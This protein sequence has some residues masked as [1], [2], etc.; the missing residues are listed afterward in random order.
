MVEVGVFRITKTH[1][2]CDASFLQLKHIIFRFGIGAAVD[3]SLAESIDE[4]GS[5]KLAI[6]FNGLTVH[7]EETVIS[8]LISPLYV[9][10]SR[11]VFWA[12]NNQFPRTREALLHFK[13]VLSLSQ[14]VVVDSS[15]IT[16]LLLMHQD[17]SDE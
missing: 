4:K 9:D 3:T 6:E 13:P 11:V 1:Y 15:L 10:W 17:R 7:Q 5:L 12:L 16:G 2:S 8:L 14:N